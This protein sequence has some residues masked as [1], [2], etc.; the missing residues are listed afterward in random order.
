MC[1]R[2]TCGALFILIMHANEPNPRM[3]CEFICVISGE[4]TG[5]D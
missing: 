5:A 2:E 3:R 4:N 1:L